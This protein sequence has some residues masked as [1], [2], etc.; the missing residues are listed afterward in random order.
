VTRAA[1][2]LAALVVL[3]GGAACCGSGS[4]PALRVSAAS[5]L[6][7][8]LTEIAD[9]Y[10][11]ETGVHV[12]LDSAGSQTLATRIVEGAPVHVFASADADPVDA[13]VASGLARGPGEVFAA[14]TLAIAVP[15]G[16]PAGIR[17]L[18]D[19]ARSGASL[20]LCARQVPCGR[21]A[22]RALDRAGVDAS[23][24]TEELDV[25][26]LVT[27]VEA[28]ELD[29]AVV[30]RSD[31][32]GARG[33]LGHVAIAD[34]DNVRVQH[35]IVA[36]RGGGAEA[37]AFVDFVRSPRAARILRTVGFDVS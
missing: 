27:K 14:N 19:F 17:S 32:V 30:Y 5:S 20:G 36:L 26:A 21:A 2:A 9:A 10:E 16:N 28:G 8:A 22:R 23:V 25:R 3:V 37:D 12:V 24:D 18:A 4:G 29:A 31:I 33:H 35:V 6:T 13:V 11:R 1:P 34:D 15:L 7:A